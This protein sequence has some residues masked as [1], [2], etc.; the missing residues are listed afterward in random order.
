[1]IK[2]IKK[3]SMNEKLPANSEKLFKTFEKMEIKLNELK[4]CSI[5]KKRINED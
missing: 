4:N 2:N 5:S 1:M 3:I